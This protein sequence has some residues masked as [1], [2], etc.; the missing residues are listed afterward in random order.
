LAYFAL[1]RLD[2][3]AAGVIA[4]HPVLGEHHRQEEPD[5]LQLHMGFGQLISLFL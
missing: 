5:S 1:H 3:H 2:E 4:V